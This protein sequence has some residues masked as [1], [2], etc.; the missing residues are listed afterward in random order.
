MT[1]L[2]RAGLPESTSDREILNTRSMLET[3]F[4]EKYNGTAKI[5]GKTANVPATKITK[6]AAKDIPA[7]EGGTEQLLIELYDVRD[8][9]VN[10]FKNIDYT[11]VTA[12]SIAKHINKVGSCIKRL[13]GEVEDF[14]PL[15]HVSGLKAPPM[16]PLAERVIETTSQCYQLGAIKKHSISEDGKIII[17]S[18]TGIHAE[19]S[20]PYSAKGTITAHRGWIGNEAIDYVYTPGEGKMSVK[21]FEKGQWVD[22]SKDEDYNIYWELTEM[23]PSNSKEESKII[24]AG[25]EMVKFIEL[26]KEKFKDVFGLDLE[27]K[28]IMEN[29]PKKS[30]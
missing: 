30:Q 16:T 28:E 20:T 17:L 29:L 13:G 23:E 4:F 2:G 21:A 25:K 12:Q 15:N 6:T 18:F 8:G 26:F 9:L 22:K 27:I 11:S 24:E 3:A 5:A 7:I 19:S 1:E 14:I 10:T